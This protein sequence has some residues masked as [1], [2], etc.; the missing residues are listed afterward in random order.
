[1]SAVLIAFILS[2]FGL[3]GAVIFILYQRKVVLALR[4]AM[5]AEKA[6]RLAASDDEETLALLEA[7][8][9]VSPLARKLLASANDAATETK[10]VVYLAQM[11]ET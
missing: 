7:S 6:K 9:A 5:D 10:M 8:A 11:K 1:M 3:L 4:G 2:Y